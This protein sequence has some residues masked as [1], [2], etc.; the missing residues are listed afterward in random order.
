MVRAATLHPED[1]LPE[2][3]RQDGF[4]HPRET[5]ALFGH[6]AAEKAFLD[7]FA[8]GRMHHAWLLCGPAGIGKATL[9][10]RFAKYA[11]AK[12]AE[13][14]PAT[15]AIDDDASAARQVTAL[16]HPGLL[17]LRR[18]FDAKTKRFS[19]AITVDEVRRLRSFLGLTASE[20]SWRIVIVDSANDLNPNAANALLKSLE[21]P[22][23]QTTFLLI[24]S[25]P[26]A[27]LPT[28]RSR[29]RRVNLSPL[30]SGDLRAAAERAFQAANIEMPK[31]D[32]WPHLEQVAKGSVR[33]VLQFASDGGLASHAAL[34]GA[35]A[36]LPAVDWPAT[37]AL[38]DT[39]SGSANEQQFEMFC[40]LLLEMTGRMASESSRD[41]ARR[42]A[43]LTDFWSTF[44]RQ[45]SEIDLLNL[46]RKSFIL[47]AFNSLQQAVD[48]EH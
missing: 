20:G 3:D 9:A 39:L 26:S 34:A 40:D 7:G 1:A 14:K 15:L 8:D 43:Q 28:I 36:R 29:C 31:I 13:R 27:L 44:V 35:L 46:D 12:P 25:E 24:S 10:Y 32:Q 11:L 23:S 45:R 5:T 2:L 42:S 21:E 41:N 6:Q 4:L 18:P 16:S 19:S 48:K 38:A 30:G 22:P 17:V 47:S 37:H 33:R